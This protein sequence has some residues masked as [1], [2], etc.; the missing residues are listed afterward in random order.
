MSYTI[1]EENSRTVLVRMPRSYLSR[2]DVPKKSP[3]RSRLIRD[4][5]MTDENL[6]H[7][8]EAKRDLENGVNIVSGDDFIRKFNLV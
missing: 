2:L 6:A 8:L 4:D 3:V 1:L 7:Y 5:E